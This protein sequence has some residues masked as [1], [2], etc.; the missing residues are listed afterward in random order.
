M[1]AVLRIL[2]CCALL[3]LAACGSKPEQPQQE[4][5][6]L[7]AL[8]LAASAQANP[9]GAGRASPVVVRIYVLAD[10]SE[11]M[12]A[13]YP[14]IYVDDR[15]ALPAGWLSR[16][17]ALMAPGANQELSLPLPPTATALCALAAFREVRASRWRIC[18][19]LPAS[20]AATLQ[21]T[22]NADSIAFGDAGP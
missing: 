10:R 8:K 15:T 22:V 19:A 14:A 5:P 16:Q 7:Q 11:F 1:N 17:E 9:D 3:L 6:R 18:T 20:R 2:P 13:D 21:L 4:A 12:A